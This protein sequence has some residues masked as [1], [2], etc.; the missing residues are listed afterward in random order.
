MVEL[1]CKNKKHKSYTWD[2]KGKSKF[3]ASCPKC[4]SSIRVIKKVVKGEET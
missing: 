4:H 3:F 2:Y 1:T